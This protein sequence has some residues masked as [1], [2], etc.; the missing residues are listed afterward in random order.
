[1]RIAVV[2]QH[3][4][5]VVGGSELQCD[6]VAQG[7]VARGHDVAYVAVTPSSAARPDPRPSPPYAMHRVAPN[8][9]A[10]VAACAASRADVVYWRM[11]RPNLPGV[12]R[13]LREHRIPL[14]FAIA[15]A[16]DVA[17][18]P[19]RPWPRGVA[20]RDHLHELRVRFRHRR[21]WAA[22][23][24]VDAIASQRAD[25]IGQ[26]PVARQEL[27][28]NLMV[29]DAEPFDRPRPYVAWVGSLQQRKRPELLPAVADAVAPLGVDVVV[30]GGLRDDRYRAL[31]EPPG[32]RPNLHHVGIL[33][34][35]QVVGLLAGARALVMTAHEEGFANVL[36]QAWWHGT[37]TVSLGYDPDATIATHDLGRACGEDVEHFVDEVAAFATDEGEDAA[38]RR[39]HIMAFARETF[40][41]EATLD[42]LE[43]LLDDVW[44]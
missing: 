30:A 44:R 34:Q 9:D 31:V 33:R 3:P 5:D 38:R 21:S 19:V 12:V 32:A 40:A 4:S 24:G 41:A 43:R 35:A 7:L 2:N 36:L 16:D 29:E 26:A 28:R 39:A 23:G 1:M 13:G 15:H 6:L 25:L 18:W 11:N 14:V 8:A 20:P 10:I 37:P 27:V 42:A 17:R 22:F